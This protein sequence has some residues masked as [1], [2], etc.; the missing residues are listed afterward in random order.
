MI[1]E[2]EAGLGMHFYH[3]Y[4][5]DKPNRNILNLELVSALF[6]ISTWI[7]CDSRTAGAA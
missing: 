4:Q 6:A 2:S 7:T 3:C 1:W 5:V